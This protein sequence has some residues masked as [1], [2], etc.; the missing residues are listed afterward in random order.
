MGIVRRIVFF[1]YDFIVGDDW[2]I[3]VG[4][5]LALGIAAVLTRS[6]LDGVAWLV[7]P[8]TAALV[9]WLSLMRGAR[10]R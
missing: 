4:A 1:W 7:L 3:A 8:L 10:A 5:L 9:L 6:T 2:V